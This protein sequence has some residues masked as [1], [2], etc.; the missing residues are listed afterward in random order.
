MDHL[1]GCFGRSTSA[2]RD[3][4]AWRPT[5]PE[6]PNQI[7]RNRLH[8]AVRRTVGYVCS[9]WSLLGLWLGDEQ[10]VSMGNLINA[11]FEWRTL[12][13]VATG[14]EGLL[15]NRS[16]HGTEQ[17]LGVIGRPPGQLSLPYYTIHTSDHCLPASNNSS[18]GVINR[19]G[20]GWEIAT[21]SPQN[22]KWPGRGGGQI[23]WKSGFDLAEK[24]E[25]N[26]T[27]DNR[28]CQRI[29]VA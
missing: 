21:P 16:V 23:S 20:P 4:I 15:I 6:Q 27:G 5:L 14:S 9:W 11:C 13:G 29:D 25:P 3:S 26:G 18:S 24:G 17:S 10:Y 28:G 19:L 8:D 7:T 1:C 22:L 12:G 2:W